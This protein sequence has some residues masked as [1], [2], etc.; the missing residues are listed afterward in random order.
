MP[1]TVDAFHSVVS[2]LT[3]CALCWYCCCCCS[4]S[5]YYY[6]YYSNTG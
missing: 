4:S 1:L 6:C 2:L 5:C 3:I